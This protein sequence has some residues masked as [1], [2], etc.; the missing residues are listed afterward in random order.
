[1]YAHSVVKDGARAFNGS[2]KDTPAVKRLLNQ[3]FD[4]PVRGKMHPIN[5]AIRSE[6]RDRLAALGWA[7]KGGG[8]SARYALHRE[9]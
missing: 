1:M 2:A 8:T 5:H 3:L 4:V 9:L 7:T 6:C